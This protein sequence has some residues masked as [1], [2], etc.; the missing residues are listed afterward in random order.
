M[1]YFRRHPAGK[2]KRYQ[3]FRTVDQENFPVSFNC[4]VIFIILGL[5]GICLPIGRLFA[6]DASKIVMVLIL[7]V[8]IWEFARSRIDRKLKEEMPEDDD[9]MEEVGCR[10][11]AHRNVTVYLPPGHRNLANAG[12]EETSAASGPKDKKVLA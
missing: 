5:W 8:V 12:G 7:G 11:F 3:T 2:K 1:R 9:E 6:A 10:W 4:I